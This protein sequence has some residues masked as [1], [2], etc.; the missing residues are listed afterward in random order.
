MIQLESIN[1][2]PPDTQI[3]VRHAILTVYRSGVLRIQQDTNF[4]SILHGNRD[5]TPED[6]AKRILSFR[7]DQYAIDSFV[8]LAKEV[9]IEHEA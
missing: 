6:L 1:K 2:L 7:K 8:E 5:E 3:A 4:A 9:E